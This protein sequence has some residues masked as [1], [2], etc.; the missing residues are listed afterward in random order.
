[1]NTQDYTEDFQYTDHYGDGGFESQKDYEESKDNGL[2]I[3]NEKFLN[4]F[5]QGTL[6]I[7]KSDFCL[8]C[9]GRCHEVKYGN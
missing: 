3:K 1:M 9:Q 6:P 5:F 7:D 4:D 8:R 2:D